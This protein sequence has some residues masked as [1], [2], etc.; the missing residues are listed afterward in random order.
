VATSSLTQTEIAAK[1]HRRAVRFFWALLIGA[2]T[3]S[4]IGNIA[5]AVL[6]Y[7]PRFVIQIGA[8]A[9]APIALLAAFHGIA[10]AVRAGRRARCTAARSA[11]L[12]LSGQ[13]RSP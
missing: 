1:N 13:E 3:V 4:L 12:Q 2:T 9:V 7:L 11:L 5:H 10:L 6:P 8:A